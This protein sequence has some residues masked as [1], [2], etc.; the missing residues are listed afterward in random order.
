MPSSRNREN[1]VKLGN[2]GWVLPTFLEKCW[3][4]KKKEKDKRKRKRETSKEKWRTTKAKSGNAFCSEK[5]KKKRLVKLGNQV[6]VNSNQVFVSAT[7][8]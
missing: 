3:I 7:S 8:K 2:N 4:E 1:P 5:D 6:K